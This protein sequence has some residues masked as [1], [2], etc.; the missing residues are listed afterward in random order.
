MSTLLLLALLSGGETE[1]L[2]F[3]LASPAFQL[4]P[5]EPAVPC[6][7]DMTTFEPDPV[8]ILTDLVVAYLDADGKHKTWTLRPGILMSECGFTQVLNIKAERQRMEVEVRVLTHL[9][10]FYQQNWARAEASYQDRILGLEKERNAALE[11]SWWDDWKGP[12]MFVLGAITAV[13]A[14]LVVVEIVKA[15]AKW[16]SALQ[17]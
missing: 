8:P 11:S 17:P 1:G 7:S 5:P 4:P 2:G 14:T 3:S 12:T 10:Q 6:T 15:E 16:A 9:T 13:A